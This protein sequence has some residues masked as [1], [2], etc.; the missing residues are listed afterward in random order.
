M[1]NYL[2]EIEDELKQLGLLNQEQELL[3]I[4]TL[5][6][7][8][9]E[10][11]IEHIFYLEGEFDADYFE[12]K[13]VELFE[14]NELFIMDYLRVNEEKIS[15][16][17]LI[18]GEVFQRDF[19]YDT[20]N[21]LSAFFSFLIELNVALKG[22]FLRVPTSF[23]DYLFLGIYIENKLKAK[24][25]KRLFDLFSISS[26][27][28]SDLI[29]HRYSAKE[30]KSRLKHLSCQKLESHLSFEG[31]RNVSVLSPDKK[32][33]FLGCGDGNIYV[34]N[35]ESKGYEAKFSGHNDHVLSLAVHPRKNLLISGACLGDGTLK[36]WDTKNYKLLKTIGEATPKDAEIDRDE[37]RSYS[38]AEF[39]SDGQYLLAFYTRGDGDNMLELFDAESFSLLQHEKRKE[40]NQ[41]LLS[42]KLHI[43]FEEIEQRMNDDTLMKLGEEEYPFF[44]KHLWKYSF[45]PSGEEF[46]IA[47]DVGVDFWHLPSMSLLETWE[48]SEENHMRLV[49]EFSYINSETVALLVG[50]EL[51]IRSKKSQVL[52]YL[53]SNVETF[54]FYEEKNLLAFS[55]GEK[56]I[57]F[58]L[59]EDKIVHQLNLKEGMVTLAFSP[60]GK[61][62]AGSQNNHYLTVWDV[63]SFTPVHQESSGQNDYCDYYDRLVFTPNKEHLLAL[64]SFRN[65]VHI[66][67]LNAF[68]SWRKWRVVKEL[69]AR[70]IAL[71][72]EGEMLAVVEDELEAIELFSTKGWRNKESIPLRW[73][74]A[75][76]HALGFSPD[77]RWIVFLNDKGMVQLYSSKNPTQKVTLI[78]GRKG[79]WIV[80][81][82]GK[83]RDSGSLQAVPRFLVEKRDE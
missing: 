46:A 62:L 21:H 67:Q 38:H 83:I 53:F 73:E 74:E 35:H 65:E 55:T 56:L 31:R 19:S 64:N 78:G 34:W 33:F 24:K 17:L 68:F 32:L 11:S 82:E 41:S 37:N 79:E 66:R 1:K 76:S 42:G 54:T 36:L 81:E 44:S 27:P 29:F 7:L 77:G 30:E 6:T 47:T 25:L 10:E 2:K 72:P 70:A 13:C 60:D 57:L 43:N 9:I 15:L 71:S 23:S 80:M 40:K 16:K 20:D 51:H 69:D 3:D 14:A 28:Q 26:E 45:D 58:S 5:I 52:K 48:I 63:E 22:E 50:R 39:T 8:L 12:R 4:D 59:F 49:S 61:L 18:N 75:S